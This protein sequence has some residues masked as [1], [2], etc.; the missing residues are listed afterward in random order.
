[1]I[2]DYFLQ[3]FLNVIRSNLEEYEP[4]IL[5]GFK[6]TF[7]N[8]YERPSKIAGCPRVD[9]PKKKIGITKKLWI[10]ELF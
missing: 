7:S 8:W 9:M 6:S 5:T 1:M 4:T 3:N 2:D 10:F